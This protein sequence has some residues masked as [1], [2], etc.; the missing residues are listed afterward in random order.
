M[1]CTALLFQGR[2]EEAMAEGRVARELYRGPMAGAGLCAVYGLLGRTDDAARELARVLD[3]ARTVAAP[4]L[5]MAWCYLGLGDD[6]VF[7]WLGYAIDARD[8]AVT[9]MPSMPLYDGIRG[10][11]RFRALLARMGLA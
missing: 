6:R 5:A 4:P 2:G 9:H 11:P 7:E 8:P 1:L 10:D 3:A